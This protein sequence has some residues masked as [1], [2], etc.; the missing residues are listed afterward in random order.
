MGM[1]TQCLIVLK[2]PDDMC[3]LQDTVL[4][5]VK[6]RCMEVDQG[7]RLVPAFYTHTNQEIGLHKCA[8]V[9]IAA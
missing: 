2:Q 1:C 9:S 8:C 7:P 5:L 4:L 6:T 3:D